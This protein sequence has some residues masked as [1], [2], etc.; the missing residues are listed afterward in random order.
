MPGPPYSVVIIYATEDLRR[1]LSVVLGAS[2]QFVVRGAA[3]DTLTGTILVRE[4]DPDLVV[5]D[6]AVPP[7]DPG[8]TVSLIRDVATGARVVIATSAP[9]TAVG[10]GWAAQADATFEKW[11]EPPASLVASLVDVIEGD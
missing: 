7:L 3:P 5:L 9:P 10:A 2:G 4:L 1:V 11:A 8:R 6:D